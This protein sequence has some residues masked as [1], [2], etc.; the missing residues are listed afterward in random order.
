MSAKIFISAVSDEFRDYRDQLRSD[1]TRHNVEV[2]VQEDFKDLGVV[3][4]DKLDLYIGACDAVIH[5]VGEM[6]GS[7]AKPASTSAIITKYPDI[8][9]RLLPLREPFDK[10]LAISYTQW[11]A[12]LALY[13]DK[14]LLIA[15]ADA[16]APRGPNY[17]PTGGSRA[18]QRTHLERLRAV[19]RYPGITFT[20]LDNLAKKIAYS[21]ILDLLVQQQREESSST[22]ESIVSVY[23]LLHL[24]DGNK[25]LAE[26][27]AHKALKIDL[28]ASRA[29]YVLGLLK[30]QEPITDISPS[31]ADE[32]E[33]CLETAAGAGLSVQCALP[34]A[35]LRIDH[36]MRRR[37]KERVPSLR[38]LAFLYGKYHQEAAQWPYGL[39]NSRLLTSREFKRIWFR[40]S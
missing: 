21:A 16:T 27:F 26:L 6:T 7:N 3:T 33:H 8:T 5:L 36:Y 13:H 39:L 32:A 1:L 4:L 38:D 40:Q 22:R 31:N 17:A 12:W 15:Q 11:E 37:R 20:G 14:T 29:W 9:A 10:Q 25:R 28:A 18:A 24:L 19:E 30:L 2:K 34:R 23:A 35:A